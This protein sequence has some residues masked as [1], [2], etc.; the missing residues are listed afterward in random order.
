MWTVTITRKAAKL[1]EK[2]PREIQERFT[3]IRLM[4]VYYV[5]TH[6]KAPY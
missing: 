4:E 5:G 1:L 2:I 3:E 6:E